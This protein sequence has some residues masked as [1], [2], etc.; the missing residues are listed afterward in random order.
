LKGFSIKSEK[1]G[2]GQLLKFEESAEENATS[3]TLAL[4]ST[5]TIKFLITGS[6]INIADG[7]LDFSEVPNK[8]PVVEIKLRNAS[9]SAPTMVKIKMVNN[10]ALLNFPKGEGEGTVTIKSDFK[11]E[12][13]KLVLSEDDISIPLGQSPDNFYKGVEKGL[14]DKNGGIQ[15]EDVSLDVDNGKPIYQ[16][17]IKEPVKLLWLIPLSINTDVIA[18]AADNSIQKVKR[19]WYSFLLSKADISNIKLVPDF[20]VTAIQLI[21]ND[22]KQGDKI[23]AKVTITNVGTA[24]GIS[25]Y[26]I[27][28]GYCTT[29]AYYWGQSQIQWY[30]SLLALN[31]GESVTYDFTLSNAECQPFKFVYDANKSIEED[32][33]YNNNTLTYQGNCS[34]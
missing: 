1:S 13:G 18:N 26:N 6:Q 29:I 5:S 19:P 9:S 16:I 7:T 21:P 22:Y 12:E 14:K 23:T 20:A 2:N 31:I 4:D 15:L 32:P 24:I 8:T 28:S 11:I 34:Q 33:D 10:N 27:G 30:C 17:I 3:T 25:H